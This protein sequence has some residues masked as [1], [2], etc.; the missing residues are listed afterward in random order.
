MYPNPFST[1]PGREG[2]PRVAMHGLT[3]I[4]IPKHHSPGPS[5]SF[6]LAKM[7]TFIKSPINTSSDP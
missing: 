1:P 4:D 6:T 7:C 5:E 2:V 3:I